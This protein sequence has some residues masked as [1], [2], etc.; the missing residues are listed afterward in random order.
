MHWKNGASGQGVEHILARIV[1]INNMIA[2]C[3]IHREIVSPSELYRF[4]IIMCLFIIP[5]RTIAL[6]GCDLRTH[7]HQMV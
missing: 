2:K 7:L 4:K 5:C 3:L 6:S 1:S